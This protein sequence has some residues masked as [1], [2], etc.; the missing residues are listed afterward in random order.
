MICRQ[1]VEVISRSLDAPLSVSTRAGL[2]VHTLFCSPCRRFRRQLVQ[3]HAACAVIVV[4]S[5]LT[6][7]RL[8]GAAR[9]RVATALERLAQEPGPGEH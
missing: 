7:G 4:D 9:T 1:A 8:S 6:E 3:V 5:D 2:Y